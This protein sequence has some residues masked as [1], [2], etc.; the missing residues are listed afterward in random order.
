VAQE[1]GMK[2]GWAVIL[3][4]VVG[5]PS[6]LWAQTSVDKAKALRTR[7]K[8]MEAKEA[9]IRSRLRS[10]KREVWSVAAELQQID[11][12]ASRLESRLVQTKARLASE[13]V[14]QRKLDRELTEQEEALSAKKTLLARRLRSIYMS[15]GETG[16]SVLIGARS[17]SE[18]AGRKAFTERIAR[19]DR[20]LLVSVRELRDS[21]A[22]KK[23]EKDGVVARIRQL[24]K[25]QTAQ[26]AELE[27]A[28]LDKQ[29]ALNVLRSERQ[30][31]ERQLE[32]MERESERI[33][34]QIRAYLAVNRSRVAAY[35]GRFVMPVSGRWSSGF[36]MRL[37]PI[38][39]RLRMHNGQDIAAP[40]GIPVLAAAP[41][42]VIST[43]WRGGYGQTVIIDHGGGVSTLYAHC[44]SIVVSEGQSVTTGQRIAKVGS[45]GLSTGP[46]L[47]FEVRVNGSPVDPSL[48]LGR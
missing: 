13:L 30:E 38:T 12:R 47:H 46:H 22:R 28:M 5:T 6:A 35:R 24:H 20:E 44:S 33:E 11:E 41:G 21:V 4:A 39:R 19:R 9:L 3:V 10:K 32:E 42:L 25:D 29:A 48:Y 1:G 37:H 23:R 15:R 14:E 34:A 26:A 43:G 45:T 31:L 7:L 16:L 8:D 27:D 17:M 18:F 40:H 36:G 2:R